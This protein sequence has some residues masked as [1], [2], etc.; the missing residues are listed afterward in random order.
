MNVA[1]LLTS[2]GINIGICVVLFSLYSILRKQ[3]GNVSVYFGRRLAYRRAK[4][5]DPFCL[6]R[7]VPSPSWILK[8]WETTEDELLAVGGLDAVV[9][10]RIVAF[11]IRIFSVAAVICTFLVL[12]VNYYGHEGIHK[13]I[14]SE[15]LDAFTIKNVKE[16][17]DWLWTHC[18]ALYIITC[19]S[20]LL[21]YF[22]FKNIAKMR[23]A[24]IIGSPTSP[25]HFAIL[26]RGIPWCAKGSYCDTVKKFF[27]N[28]HAASYLS[29]QMVYKSGTVHKLMNDAEKMCNVFK[30][31]SVNQNCMPSFLRCGFCGEPTNSFRKLS[32][33]DTV[34]GRSSYVDM[35]L[36]SR[37][38]ECAAAFVFFK[39]RYAAIVASQVLQSSNPMLW[40][41][42]LAPEPHDVYWPNLCIPY[43]QLWI[44]KIGTLMASIAFMLVF[45]VPV[46]FVQG[47]TELDKLQLRLPF[48][49]GILKN[50]FIIQLVTGYLPSVILIL[51]LYAVPPM[52]M[53]FSAVE[54]CISR[55]GRKK[56][57][58]YKILYFTIWNVFYVNIF[59]G[60]FIRQLDVFSSVKEL[61]SQLAKAV[62]EQ[63]TFFIT[64]VLSSGWAS[65]A[66]EL[67]QFFPLFCNLFSRF[68]LRSKDNSSDCTLSFPY[69]TEVPRVLLFGFLGFTCSILAP[70]ILPFL[71]VYFFLAYLV[72]RNQ[73]INVYV[74]KYESGGQFW[75]IAHK[76]TVFSL[77]FTQVVALGVFSIKRSTA[78]TG[79]TIPLIIITLLFHEYCRQRF[80]PI[81]NNH[82][83]E[84]LIKLDRQ[85]EET[86]RMEEI[87]KQLHSAYCQLTITS[88][89]SCPS[90]SLSH[91]LDRS[92]QDPESSRQV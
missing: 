55:S 82:V 69:H 41:T 65:L 71:L 75:P 30:A 45:L 87:Y 76:T 49:R 51:F 83:A 52:M 56:S 62:P 14:P 3:P 73:I 90:Q 1:A 24:H 16:G 19:S 57:A 77:V 35:H 78:A 46:T 8:A 27:S 18:L 47:L 43:R 67:M 17:S 4:C 86:G 39:T 50:K 26:V 60:S 34:N 44:R 66:C 12:P 31:T 42:D 11:S 58:C 7:F 36:S 5:I 92:I 88:H 59:T 74:S 32:D 25:S 40:V 81:F 54:G 29:H 63:A 9:F 13:E 72:Y 61:P 22:E 89:D 15:S 28:Y 84:V 79:F 80:L 64:Y 10:L 38:K 33:E 20:G 37:K 68:I 91:Q 70:L 6:E 85:D 21:L 48:L 2:A 53:L 23:L